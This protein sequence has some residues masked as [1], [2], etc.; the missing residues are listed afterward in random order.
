MIIC[1]S[2]PSEAPEWISAATKNSTSIELAWKPVPQ[3]DLNGYLT[4]YVIRYTDGEEEIQRKVGRHREEVVIN[5]LRASTTYF[6]QISAAT[7]KG[8]GPRSKPTEAKTK[9]ERNKLNS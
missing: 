5:G 9:G 2:V 4:N 3:R 1:F 8:E 7:D 6:F